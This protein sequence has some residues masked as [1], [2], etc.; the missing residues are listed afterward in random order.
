[1]QA[2]NL[3]SWNEVIQYVIGVL[4]RLLIACVIPYGFKLLKEKWHNDM[5]NK[6]LDKAEQ[7]I[8]DAVDQVQQTYVNDLKAE[9]LFDKEAQIDAFNMVK[10]NVINMMNERMQDVVFEAVGDFDTFIRNKIEAEV[11]RIKEN[12]GNVTAVKADA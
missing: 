11:F 2:A 3:M 9:D 10:T 5:V 7:F 1:M 4:L 6:Y 8:K 12:A